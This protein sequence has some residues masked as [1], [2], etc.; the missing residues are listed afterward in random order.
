MPIASLHFG[1]VAPRSPKPVQ[2]MACSRESAG[3]T[4]DLPYL[5][6]GDPSST[7]PKTPALG[8]DLIGPRVGE[9]HGSQYQPVLNNQVLLDLRNSL[10][11]ELY[12]A[13]LKAWDLK[14]EGLPNVLATELTADT[15]Y[16][17]SR[18][19]AILNAIA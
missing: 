11:G 6:I 17:Q 9:T 1:T 5:V 13:P 3:R 10:T 4:V 15:G 12:T 18:A 7:N 2:L 19:A 14:K 16:N 8:I